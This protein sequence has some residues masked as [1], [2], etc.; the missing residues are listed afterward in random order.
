MSIT[1]FKNEMETHNYSIEEKLQLVD[2]TKHTINLPESVSTHLFVNTTFPDIYE[3]ILF[4]ILKI[5]RG[6]DY[7]GQLC[8]LKHNLELELK[9]QKV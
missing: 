8:K 7:E 9:Q 2:F 4:T 3:Y 5:N 1:H 6:E